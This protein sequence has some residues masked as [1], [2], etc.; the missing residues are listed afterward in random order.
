M[1]GD[2]NHRP[3]AVDT[4]TP[5]TLNVVSAVPA[6]R[7]RIHSAGD[8]GLAATSVVTTLQRR[9][10]RWLQGSRR[11][12]T[13]LSL[14]IH[15][16][17]GRCVFS[18]DDAGPM[19]DVTLPPGTYHVCAERGSVRR[20]YTIALEPGASFELNLHDDHDSRR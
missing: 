1:P 5:C 20:R 18:L 3:H 7:L 6:S 8:D 16:L 9:V 10:V 14:T 2:R 4:C 12:Q 13:R 11:L 15:D 17:Q 19:V